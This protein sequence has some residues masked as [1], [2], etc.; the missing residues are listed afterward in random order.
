MKMSNLLTI[1][2]AAKVLGVSTKTLRRWEEKGYLVPTRR[3]N[4]RLYE[5]DIIGYWNIMLSLDKKMSNHIKLLSRLRKRLNKRYLAQGSTPIEN[6]KFISKKEI[7]K[8]IKAFA[9]ME[10]WHRD[11]RKMLKWTT[12][13]PRLMI[14]EE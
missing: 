10:A 8:F 6:P 2:E 7:K 14:R 12:E 5:P 13:Y 3:S 1:S 9:N 11:Y 4:I